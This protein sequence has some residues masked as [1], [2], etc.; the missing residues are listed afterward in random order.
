M[1]EPSWFLVVDLASRS[2]RSCWPSWLCARWLPIRKQKHPPRIPTTTPADPDAL[3]SLQE[4]IQAATERVTGAVVAVEGPQPAAARLGAFQP[5]YCSGVIITPEG[6]ILSQFHVSH[7]LPGQPNHPDGLKRVAD[8]ANGQPSSS[9]TAASCKRNCW[10]RTDIR[11]FPAP[12]GRVGTLSLCPA[13]SV[14]DGR[15]R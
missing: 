5:Q 15:A 12:A 9:T 8:R 1:G 10:G 13:R 7:R 11:P 4:R 3:R 14:R 6:L 2:C